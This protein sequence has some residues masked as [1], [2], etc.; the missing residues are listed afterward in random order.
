MRKIT[1]LS[2]ED[3]DKI[4]LCHGIR[5]PCEV[6]KEYKIGLTRLYKIWSKNPNFSPVSSGVANVYKEA[7]AQEIKKKKELEKEIAELHQINNQLREEVASEQ[8]EKTLIKNEFRELR[9]KKT[10]LIEN[11]AELKKNSRHRR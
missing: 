6:S 9:K 10:N 5:R 8:R 2:L 11:I 1:Y 4:M 3:E 7:R